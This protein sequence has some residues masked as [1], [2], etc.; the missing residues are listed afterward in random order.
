MCDINDLHDQW[1]R[2]SRSPNWRRLRKRKLHVRERSD[3][4]YAVV[5]GYGWEV[6]FARFKTRD[7]AD[8]LIAI[9]SLSA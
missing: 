8:K 1:V 5:D 2:I 6:E 7:C 4:T 3:G 9:A